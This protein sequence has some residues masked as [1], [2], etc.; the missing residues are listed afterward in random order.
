MDPASWLL[1]SSLAQQ[2]QQPGMHAPGA[3]ASS[4]DQT[5]PEMSAPAAGTWGAHSGLDL[6]RILQAAHER[7][8]DLMQQRSTWQGGQVCSRNIC[9]CYVRMLHQ[10]TY[11]T[12]PMST[13]TVDPSLAVEVERALMR[14]CPATAQ[15]WLPFSR[16]AAT[17]R[18]RSRRRRSCRSATRPSLSPPQPWLKLRRRR[19]AGRSRKRSRC[20]MAGL[21]L[22]IGCTVSTAIG[23]SRHCVSR[24]PRSPLAP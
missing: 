10:L 7:V 24:W 23:S 12:A 13:C 9:C 11:H 14:R 16:Q 3:T 4:G 2:Q 1:G 5:V 8:V 18:S 15:T 22:V 21:G 19:R 20:D 17:L 6:H